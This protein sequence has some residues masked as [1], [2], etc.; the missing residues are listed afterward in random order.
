MLPVP[1][2]CIEPVSAQA[3]LRQGFFVLTTI[4]VCGPFWS[5]G[6]QAHAAALYRCAD[7][8]GA[9]VFTDTPVQLQD[10]RAL[11]SEAAESVEVAPVRLP[12]PAPSTPASPEFG[13]DEPD[14]GTAE[15]EA[16]RITVPVRRVGNLLIVT[17]RV[18]GSRDAHLILDTGASHT[19]LSPDVAHD[20]G[21]LGDPA[22]HLVTLNTAGGP[23]QAEMVR[24][25]SIRIAEAE[26]QNSLAAIY[27]LPDSPPGIDGLLGLTFLRQF[28]VTL[29]TAKGLLYLRKP[30]N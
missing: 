2:L 9:S 21:L 3:L 8:S 17:T 5:L 12:T 18:N 28:Q 26:V 20:L 14:R 19:I 25:E 23:V 22:S 13:P 16:G 11:E 15:H 6:S 30:G 27:A 29:D 10:C 4:I 1:H 7:A 24:V